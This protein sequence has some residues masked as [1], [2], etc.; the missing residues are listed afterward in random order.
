MAAA[1]A[2]PAAVAVAAIVNVIAVAAVAAVWRG[3]AFSRQKHKPIHKS[4][5]N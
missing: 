3:F 1:V 4:D 2:A 5:V